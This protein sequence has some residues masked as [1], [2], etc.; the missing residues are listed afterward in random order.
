MSA[1]TTIDQLRQVIVETVSIDVQQLHQS[2]GRIV[3][4]NSGEPTYREALT[5]SGAK[6]DAM[7]L[8]IPAGPQRD[9]ETVFFADRIPAGLEQ[10]AILREVVQLHSRKVFPKDWELLEYGAESWDTWDK[11]T[12]EGAIHNAVSKRIAGTPRHYLPSLQFARLVFTLQEAVSRR[13]TP[14]HDGRGVEGWL[15]AALAT[16]RESVHHLVGY[17]LKD[18]QPQDMVQLLQ[19]GTPFAKEVEQ[20]KAVQRSQQRQQELVAS[21]SRRMSVLDSKYENTEQH[22]A[23]SSGSDAALLTRIADLTS[24]LNAAKGAIEGMAS[25]DADGRWYVDCYRGDDVTSLVD[26]INAK[27]MNSA[28][29]DI[30]DFISQKSQGLIHYSSEIEELAYEGLSTARG[31]FIERAAL[32]SILNS[33]QA[34]VDENREIDAR[35]ISNLI[36][37]ALFDSQITYPVVPIPIKTD[38]V[39]EN[40]TGELGVAW[41][42]LCKVENK[43]AE[44]LSQLGEARAV[45]SGADAWYLKHEAGELVLMHANVIDSNFVEH[46]SRFELAL[47]WVDLG[48]EDVQSYADRVNR[49]VNDFVASPSSLKF[50]I[51]G[52]D[53]CP[54]D[55]YC[56]DGV[57]DVDEVDVQHLMCKK[58]EL[59]FEHYLVKTESPAQF[60]D[61]WHN[62]VAGDPETFILPVHRGSKICVEGWR[63]VESASSQ[64]NLYLSLGGKFVATRGIASEEDEN[65]RTRITDVDFIVTED[66]S[67]VVAFA[68][69]GFDAIKLYETIDL[70]GIFVKNLETG[71]VFSHEPIYQR[72]NDDVVAKEVKQLAL[73]AMAC[74]ESGNHE[75]NAEFFK[76]TGMSPSTYFKDFQDLMVNE[77]QMSDLLKKVIP[78]K[79][80][81]DFS[82]HLSL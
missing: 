43:L 47:D 24:R 68:G 22:T 38:T 36:S 18:Y 23:I 51:I 2:M 31:S 4:S 16:I 56:P 65:D 60:L 9:A 79:Y 52:S 71:V 59:D 53:G 19:L 80:D 20:L 45:V 34:S 40:A 29:W 7:S 5:R 32:K 39:L 1:S 44:H 12:P 41:A 82:D 63:F 64:L 48:I 66:I 15:H 76:K 55:D 13:V 26:G 8:F 62:T 27:T 37:E 72:G 50:V 42:N 49:L 73:D 57:A 28:L 35:R 46:S 69:V 78:Q 30:N 21:R 11:T 58:F 10:R 75:E 17:D 3:V 14:V 33:V 61:Y 67:H 77:G 25:K 74:I 81:L 6:S 70:R 54:I